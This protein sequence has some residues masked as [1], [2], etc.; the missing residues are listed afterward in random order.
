MYM[1]FFG[2][3]GLP[4]PTVAMAAVAVAAVPVPVSMSVALVNLVV[5]SLHM[6]Y[7]VRLHMRYGHLDQLH[8]RYFN[9]LLNGHRAV[10]VHV[11]NLLVGDFH[12]LLN[13]VGDWFVD[14]HVLDLHY[15]HWDVLDVWH[16]DGVRL[17]YR[18][19]NSL[20]HGVRHRLG[21]SVGH[22][23]EHLVGLFTNAVLSGSAVSVGKTVDLFDNGS[24]LAGGWGVTA[25]DT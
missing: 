13:G 15:G 4:G 7:G 11:H 19:F 3:P 22:L 17:G 23:P 2:H 21:H 5:D 14:F 6:R 10:N 24:L 8:N 18:D 1:G 9:D 12:D 20:G 16:L 25:C